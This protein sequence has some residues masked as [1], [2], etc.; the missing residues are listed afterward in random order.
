[1]PAATAVIESRVLSR[2]ASS[3]MSTSLGIHRSPTFLSS[4]RERVLATFPPG[5]VT[6]DCTRAPYWVSKY[7]LTD[8]MPGFAA[9]TPPAA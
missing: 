2:V 8:L 7:A 6:S 3:R 4:N 9:E 1:M 5:P